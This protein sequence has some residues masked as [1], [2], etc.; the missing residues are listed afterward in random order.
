ML[1]I[2]APKIPNIFLCVLSSG[3]DVCV[4]SC[5][6]FN[7]WQIWTRIEIL[8]Q[9]HWFLYNQDFFQFSFLVFQSTDNIVPM[10]IK[11]CS[12]FL[13]VLV[14]YVCRK[15]TMALGIANICLLH[16]HLL[17]E[18]NVWELCKRELLNQYLMLLYLPPFRYTSFF[19]IIYR[20]C[21]PL[22]CAACIS[23]LVF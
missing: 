16:K 3:R 6:H 19:I 14:P 5:V 1:L 8:F 17:S 9:W 20:S 2:L 15:T 22:L 18:K 4:D 23:T 10:S 7:I 12:F 21:S 11:H 13:T